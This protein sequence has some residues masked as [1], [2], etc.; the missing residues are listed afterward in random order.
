VNFRK[1]GS[2]CVVCALGK[3]K[4]RMFSGPLRPVSVPGSHFYMD[5]W[6]PAECPSLLYHNVYMIGF[7]DAAT[8][9]L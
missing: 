1:I 4:R 6:G 3:S 2:P 7:I 9:Y 8:K 5:V